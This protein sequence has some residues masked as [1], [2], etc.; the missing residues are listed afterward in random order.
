MAS[1]VHMSNRH[2][3][4]NEKTETSSIKFYEANTIHF[5]PILPKFYA[6]MSLAWYNQDKR[7]NNELCR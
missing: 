6:T 3:N 1:V 5:G 4:I 2:G 7:S